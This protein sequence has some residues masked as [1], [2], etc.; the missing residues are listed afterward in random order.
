M[1]LYLECIPCFQKQALFV[2]KNQDERTRSEILKK[3]IYLLYNADWNTTPDELSHK[4]Y[5]LLRQETGIL[6]P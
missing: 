6:D 4:V 5:S 3:V 1:N 2:T